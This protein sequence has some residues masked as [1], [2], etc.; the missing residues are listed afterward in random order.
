MGGCAPPTHSA[1]ARHS[2]A[3]HASARLVAPRRSRVGGGRRHAS[4]AARAPVGRADARRA[5]SAPREGSAHRARR[6]RAACAPHAQAGAPPA[7]PETQSRSRRRARERWRRLAAALVVGAGI[8]TRRE[9]GTVPWQSGRQSA[10]RQRR[11]G[12]ARRAARWAA[13]SARC[14][15]AASA[16]AASACGAAAEARPAAHDGCGWR[17]LRQ[18]R[19]CPGGMEMRVRRREICTM[20]GVAA[21]LGGGRGAL[22]AHERRAARGCTSDPLGLGLGATASERG[23]RRS[24]AIAC[25]ARER[26]TRACARRVRAPSTQRSSSASPA[27]AAPNTPGAPPR[28]SRRPARP[29]CRAARR[30]A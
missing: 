14:R 24:I 3:A 25:S 17:Q 1:R 19:P 30:A 5:P 2:P 6:A 20:G 29:R 28:Q 9:C 11:G 4:R 16:R 27:A 7:P 12:V 22:H 23:R 18:R 21:R 15:S 26:G 8:G 13:V 10:E